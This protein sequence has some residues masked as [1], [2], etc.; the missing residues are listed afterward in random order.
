TVAHRTTTK[1]SGAGQR[2]S[3]HRAV[4]LHRGDKF[5]AVSHSANSAQPQQKRPDRGVVPTPQLVGGRKVE[6]ERYFDTTRQDHLVV[7]AGADLADGSRH[8]IAI[9]GRV[10]RYV[11]PAGAR[12]LAHSLAVKPA[13]RFAVTSLGAE[14]LNRVPGNHDS[15]AGPKDPGQW[16][17]RRQPLLQPVTVYAEFKGD[18]AK[19]LVGLQQ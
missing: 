13:D 7:A 3:D 14:K 9:A 15:G 12:H 2:L 18:P 17:S 19:N 16:G 6:R 11:H 4:V 5:R 10:G 8:P 1:R